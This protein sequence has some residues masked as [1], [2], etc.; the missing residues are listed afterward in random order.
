M[1][2]N[3]GSTP[4]D[5]GIAVTQNQLEGQKSEPMKIGQATRIGEVESTEGG[6]SFASYSVKMKMPDGGERS[7]KVRV[8]FNDAS[9]REH[10]K[11]TTAEGSELVDV[12][13][14][15]VDSMDA[16]S[17]VKL[18]GHQIAGRLNDWDNATVTLKGG[19]TK[20]LGQLAEDPNPDI[21]SLG[22]SA[23]KVIQS[24]AQ[25]NIGKLM[26]HSQGSSTLVKDAE[27][28][29][30]KGESPSLVSD[31]L[32]SENTREQGLESS[33]NKNSLENGSPA[34]EPISIE[35]KE[36]GSKVNDITE[37]GAEPIDLSE[38]GI[39]FVVT[40]EKAKS[41]ESS[42]QSLQTSRA[43]S[44][45]QD[46]KVSS[47]GSVI[48]FTSVDDSKIKNASDA[49]KTLN[50][51]TEKP[52]L[53]ASDDPGKKIHQQWSVGENSIAEETID[54][55][56]TVQKLQSSATKEIAYLKDELNNCSD[57]DID[58]KGKI[59]RKLARLEKI[60]A[61]C[62][63]DEV[64][65][66]NSDYFRD[67][68]RGD[69]DLRSSENSQG[70]KG[71]VQKFA[72]LMDEEYYSRAPAVNMRY[73]QC[74]VQNGENG[75]ES[76]AGWVRTGIISCM[77]NGF[78]NQSQMRELQEKLDSGQEQDATSLR[79]EMTREIFDS[80]KKQLKKDHK[81]VD[82]SAGY[83]LTQLGFSLDQVEEIAEI[84]KNNGDFSDIP[85]K[86]LQ[87]TKQTISEV[88]E[89]VGHVNEK[90]NQL[91][92]NQFLQVLM[93][94]IERASAEDFADGELRMLH[95][96]LLN[97]ESRKVDKTGWYHN[98][99]QE[100]QDMADIFDQFDN[101][102][103]ICDGKGP[104]IDMDGNIHL[105]QMD[106]LP[107]DGKEVNLRALYLN[108]SV[109]GY[110]KNDGT[111]R[112]LNDRALEKLQK[113]GIEEEK[114][115]QL[116]ARLTGKKSGYSSAADTVNLSLL[117]GFKVS[118]G[119]LSAKDR[120]GFVSALVMKRKM[121]E[122]GFPDRTVR[123]VIQKQVDV[124]SPAVRVVKDNTGTSV[125]KVA[126]FKIEGFTKSGGDI[127]GFTKRIL[128]F[129]RQGVE[130]LKEKKRIAQY[131]KQGKSLPEEAKAA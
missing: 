89:T 43:D 102:K 91:L 83:A 20:T 96:G 68:L 115:S 66:A 64:S 17:I 57:T 81:N 19:E 69:M 14:K 80:W 30:S 8:G 41:P 82:A 110:T 21:Q 3:T 128:L 47:A 46:A 118:T 63:Q 70:V 109:Q 36:V 130:I 93:E 22:T 131:E 42:Q 71:A 67:I 114:M 7:F 35:K 34:Q 90:R 76:S 77:D 126:P 75:K 123:N 106:Q 52:L 129:A 28:N 61:K 5:L 97:H 50:E 56:D 44:L 24:F 1:V 95:V 6:K 87:I 2:N 107:G 29:S 54:R 85:D 112:K 62:D 31:P 101:A 15:I 125:M 92:S 51:S 99:E 105:P 104:Y 78:V 48:K 11:G 124:N 58:K 60:V 18:S 79:N 23:G 73:H 108:Q 32:S 116:E 127:V 33:D 12:I 10:V 88:A 120:T 113:M 119:C 103:L 13:D 39:H 53:T 38:T 117:S 37:G 55:T 59:E 111:Q 84:A 40:E 121:E 98:E 16:S 26:G 122:S 94:H 100:M 27:G 86:T 65:W 49:V 72:T 74:D 45:L 4:Y 9:L 25:S